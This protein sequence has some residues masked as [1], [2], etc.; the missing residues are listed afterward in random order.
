[1]TSA[2]KS[3]ANRLNA[4]RST[5]PR[6]RVGK[7]RV[8]QNAFQHGLAISVASTSVY[9]VAI[10]DMAKLLAGDHAD[11]ARLDVALRIAEAQLDLRRI[12][13]FR[14]ALL[15]QWR[16]KADTLGS[17]NPIAN[18]PAR[19]VFEPDTCNLGSLAEEMM[20][21]LHKLERL[22][23]YERRAFSRRKTAIRALDDSI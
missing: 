15:S 23:R 22:D 16:T 12:R 19:I 2:A 20:A 3:A 21:L 14:V 9:A 13:Q 18:T 1:M 8:A 5:G 4:T 17:P 11:A 7:A 10:E 6:T